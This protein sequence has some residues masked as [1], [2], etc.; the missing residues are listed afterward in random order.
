[1]FRKSEDFDMNKTLMDPMATIF[2]DDND[3]YH[4]RLP[5]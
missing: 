1:M 4:H 5:P 2:F 3:D